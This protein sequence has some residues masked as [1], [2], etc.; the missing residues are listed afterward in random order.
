[1]IAYILFTLFCI[2][3]LQSISKERFIYQL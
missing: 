2:G 3:H 1:V